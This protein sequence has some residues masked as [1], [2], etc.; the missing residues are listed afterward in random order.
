MR[1]DQLSSS[2]FWVTVVAIIFVVSWAPLSI[3]TI[4]SWLNNAK[5]SFDAGYLKEKCVSV[6]AEVERRE[7]KVGMCA[8][9]CEYAWSKYSKERQ[10]MN[11]SKREWEGK[12]EKH[13]EKNN[14]FILKIK[15]SAS[16]VLF[17]CMCECRRTC[18]DNIFSMWIVPTHLEWDEFRLIIYA[19][20][21]FDWEISS[22][23]RQFILFFVLS[24]ESMIR[25]VVRRQTLTNHY[26]HKNRY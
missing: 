25:K 3:C 7:C 26:I 22:S 5:L 23:G 11:A 14:T 17:L 9:V 2:D 24:F 20:W 21:P 8:C 15:R 4:C 10:K 1:S 12:D 16:S 6:H 13:R 18:I 19:K